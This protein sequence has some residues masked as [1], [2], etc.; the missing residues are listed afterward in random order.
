[1]TFFGKKKGFGIVIGTILCAALI[2]WVVLIVGIFRKDKKPEKQSPEV[3]KPAEQ[4][5]TEPEENEPKV[6]RVYRVTE[7]SYIRG[8]KTFP[9][10]Q[11]V[12][13]EH[14]QM[15]EQKKYIN[16]ELFT[17]ITCEYDGPWLRERTER[18]STGNLIQSLEYTR[19]PN[20]GKPV[21]EYTR[22]GDG[23]VLCR[24]TYGYWENGRT[25]TKFI[26]T[27]DDIYRS[28]RYYYAEDG[29][30]ERVER[31]SKDHVISNETY[32]YD[33][34]RRLVSRAVSDEEGTEREYAYTYEGSL[35]T[36]TISSYGIVTD[37]NVYDSEDRLIESYDM[38]GD[39]FCL[40]MKKEYSG[41]N[42]V[43][44]TDYVPQTGKEQSVTEWKYDENGNLLRKTA[45]VCPE[46]EWITTESDEFEYDADGR[47]IGEKSYYWD[48]AGNLREKFESVYLEKD[49]LLSTVGIDGKGDKFAE[50]HNTY[51]E[52]G[53]CLS[54]TK[55]YQGEDPVEYLHAYQAFDVTEEYLTEEE[56]KAFG[57]VTEE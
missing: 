49:K 17:V 9:S 23:L 48:I 24:V 12:Y 45:A 10:T 20:N 40:V 11:T 34:Q 27:E 5:E 47:L 26:A 32:L 36:E 56:R 35:K 52:A 43:K 8:G 50:Y 37:K 55:W 46:N 42:C 15:K 2:A 51:D 3:T 38:Y 18:D 54:E 30:P 22:N 28:E 16:G 57:L 33:E 29:K 4:Q 39:G 6:Y 19:N 44:V 53:N 21:A 25:K 7:E 41:K 13:T 1:M 14:G 31:I